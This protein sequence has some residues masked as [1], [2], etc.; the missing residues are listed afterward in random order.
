MTALLQV[1]GL[2]KRYLGLTAVDDVSY[3]VEAGTHRRSDR[4]Q[5]LGQEHQHRL[6][7]RLPAGR[8]RRVVAGRPSISPACRRTGSRARA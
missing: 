6:H 1:R 2:T 8:W 5:R 4:P 3:E 7:Q